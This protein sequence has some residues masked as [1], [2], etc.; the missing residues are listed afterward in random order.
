MKTTQIF[1]EK[2]RCVG[3]E[4]RCAC[5]NK[6]ESYMGYDVSCERCDQLYNAFGQALRPQSQWEEQ[7]D[8]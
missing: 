1:D 6:V 3:R 5:G 4:W 7:D 2:G 8:Y